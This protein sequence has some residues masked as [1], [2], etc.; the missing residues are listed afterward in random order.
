MTDRTIRLSDAIKVVQDNLAFSVKADIIKALS[1]LPA[2]EGWR[3][4]ES[5]PRDGTPFWGIAP[6]GAGL[7]HMMLPYTMRHQGKLYSGFQYHN[8]TDWVD[9]PKP[10]PTHY[11][12]LP[13]PPV[14]G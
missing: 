2:V 8:G 1:A 6:T 5:A 11:M 10:D 7:P 13:A 4:I 12:P 9:W 14:E 3:D